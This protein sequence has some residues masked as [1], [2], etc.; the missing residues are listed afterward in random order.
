MEYCGRHDIHYKG[1]ECPRCSGEERHRELLAQA[2]D[3]V[4]ETARAIQESDYRHANPGDYEC[5][6]CRYVSLR[7]AA[8]RCPLCHGTVPTDYWSRIFE[9]EKAEAVRR[10]ASQEAAEAAWARA[11]PEREA[12]ALKS[13]IAELEE[14]LSKRWKTIG[15]SVGALAAIFLLG[16]GSS[17]LANQHPNTSPPNLSGCLLGLLVGLGALA[18]IVFGLGFYAAV[19]IVVVVVVMQIVKI[20]ALK[21]RIAK[22][23]A[24]NRFSKT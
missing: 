17:E 13:Q 20:T 9:A 6:H 10:R 14:E 3:G 19:P 1:G 21:A 2:R 22:L 18:T 15:L 16:L 23:A 8:A 4:E 12:T 5:P 11:A 7:R 24:V